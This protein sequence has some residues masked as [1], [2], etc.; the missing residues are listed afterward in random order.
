MS[1]EETKHDKD[2]S[3]EDTCFP[4]MKELREGGFPYYK[5]NFPLDETPEDRWR[6][7]MGKVFVG[8]DIAEE[9]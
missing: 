8:T 1:C 4:Q 6:S 3:S 9:G 2:Y 7:A 5:N